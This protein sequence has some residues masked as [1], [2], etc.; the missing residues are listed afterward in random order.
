MRYVLDASVGMKW[1]LPEAD[2][3]KAISLQAD[4]ESNV[5]ELL[6]PDTFPPEIAHGLTRAERRGTVQPA[7]SANLFAW[8]LTTLP[9]IHASLPLLPRAYELSSQARIGVFDCLYVALAEREQ[10]EV[11]TADVRLA[12]LFPS[13]AVLLSTVA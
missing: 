8:F 9:E 5:H 13:L 6:A 2:S 11:V 3:D 10:C 12:Q 7:T 1:I 4:F